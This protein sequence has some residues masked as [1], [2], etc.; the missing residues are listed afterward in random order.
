MPFILS[1]L[2]IESII[3]DGLDNLRRDETIVDDVFQN[4]TRVFAKSKYGQREIA[5]IKKHFIDNEVKVVHSFGDV[6]ANMPCISI[7]L[8]D[9]PEDTKLARMD[10]FED[11][12]RT[13][14]TDPAELADLIV[15]S[16]ITIDS[17]DAQSGIV[18]IDDSAD[19]SDV[20][21]N[22]ILEDI[23]GNEFNILGGVDNTNGSKKV[24][25]EPNQ[26]ILNISGPALIKSSLNFTQNE[27]R[28][29]T[30]WD[31]LLLGVHTK[32]ALTTKYLYTLVK[33]FLLSRKLDMM[34]RGI[35]LSTYSGSDF[36]R[37]MEYAGDKVYTRFLTMKGKV[38]H[39]WS[40]DKVDLIDDIQIE[41]KV[42]RDIVGPEGFPDATVQPVDREDDNA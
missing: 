35:E 10:D 31:N 24:L 39:T 41:V 7:Q 32:E 25:I 12:V 8:I 4:L 3:R 2:V 37:N 20:H 21:R 18:Y 36:N 17:Y 9:N 5:K 14:I 34:K 13:D 28:G 40:S 30:E 42:P 27:L 33:Y 38:E 1:D 22:L 23:D 6:K 26:E 29:T 16:N 11:D 19:L 15:E